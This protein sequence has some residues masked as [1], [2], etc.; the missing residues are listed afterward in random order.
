MKSIN[1]KKTS[2]EEEDDNTGRLQQGEEE[3]GT[4]MTQMKE[5]LG[6]SSFQNV[7]KE[8]LCWGRKFKMQM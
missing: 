3:S 6:L 8:N 7:V 4:W 2:D 5:M 1:T